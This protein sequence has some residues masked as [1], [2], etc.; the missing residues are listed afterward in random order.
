VFLK[1]YGLF[2]IVFLY[3]LPIFVFAFCY[4]RILMVIRRQNNKVTAG[5][6]ASHSTRVQVKDVSAS[7]NVDGMTIS[8][9]RTGHGKGVEHGN[10]YLINLMK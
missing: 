7:T 4:W 5:S 6:H 2:R 9:V 10:R 1:A 3:A 8:N